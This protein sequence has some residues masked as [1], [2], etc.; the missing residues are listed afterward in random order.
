MGHL[1]ATRICDAVQLTVLIDRDE[2]RARA[3]AEEY[4]V[5]HYATGIDAAARYAEA[6]CVAVPHDLHAP[7]SCELMSKGVHVLI[8]KPLATT[9]AE[10]DE[11]IATAERS[12]VVL[13][14]AMPRRFGKSSAFLKQL[15]QSGALGKVTSFAV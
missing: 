1:P 13:A 12:K 4:G 7:V 11:M 15:S 8:E 6:A 9:L 2:S 14:V 10:C 5:P 3:L